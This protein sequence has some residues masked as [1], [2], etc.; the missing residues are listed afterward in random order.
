[1]KN[2]TVLNAFIISSGLF[3]TACGGEE[4]K[5]YI[6]TEYDLKIAEYLA[7]KDWET[8]RTESGL[9][10]YVENP[11]S[12][13]KPSINDFLTLSYT[14]YLLD[15]TEFDG[16]NGE[17][18]SFPFPMSNLIKGWQE[19]IP[20]FGKGGKGKLIIPPAIGYG[21]QGSG[22][23]PPNSVLVFDIELFDFSAT[24]P[25]PELDRSVDYSPTIDAYIA[26]KGYEGFVKT[27]SGL[28]ILIEDAGSEM[29]PGLNDFLTLN[30]TGRLL[31]GSEFDGT[32]G[33]AT[34]FP[35]PMNNLILGWQEG[36]P[37]F[38]KGGKGKLII[39]P[40]LGYG[41]TDQETIP[42]NSILEFDIEIIDFTNTPPER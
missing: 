13:E 33:N 39:P 29:K 32:K 36:I 5:D 8:E 7:D 22:P 31:D 28:Y 21:M 4:K 17:K 1:M 42:A 2:K 15:G 16:T 38:G 3:L 18:V 23:I 9:Y 25:A 40:Y 24:P 10:I 20:S 14:G 26:E 41:G 19:G 27:E 12:E 11:G 6:E 37:S 34:T 30:Y 35:F